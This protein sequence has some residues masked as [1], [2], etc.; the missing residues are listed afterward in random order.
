[1]AKKYSLNFD[2]QYTP[3]FRTEFLDMT[4]DEKHWETVAIP[5]TNKEV[6]YNYFDEK[7]YQFESCY[8]KRITLPEKKKNKRWILHFDGV[9]VWAKVYLNGEFIGEHK[10]GYTP[11]SFDITEKAC[12]GEENS[13]VVYVDS[14]ENPNIPPFG[15]VVD[16]L[17]YG[18]IYRE[19]WLECVEDTYVEHCHI[20]TGKVLEAKK[21]IALDMEIKNYQ[22]VKEATLKLGLQFQGKEIESWSRKLKLTGVLDQQVGVDFLLEKEVQLWDIHSPNLYTFCVELVT[23]DSCHQQ[24][25]V[26]GFREIHYT[27]D[28]FFLNGKNVKLRGL[29][30]HQSFP[31]IGYAMPES[32]QKK[33]ADILKY[34]LGVNVVRSSHYPPSDHFLNRCDEIG[35]L[36]FD[37]IPGWQHIGE[38][39]Q[40]WDITKQH[41]REMIYKDWNHPSV[42]IWGVRINESQD[43]DVL[44]SE[45]NAIAREMDWSRPTG[46][47]RCIGGS[48]LL[49]DVYTYNDFVHDGGRVVLDKPKKIAKKKV[50][51]LVTEYNG[52]MFPTKKFDPQSRRVEHSLRHLRVMDK[53]MSDSDISGAIGWCMSDYNT[54]QEFGSGDKICYHGV[55]DMYRLPKYAASAYSAEGLETPVMNVAS[56]MDNGD[57]DK[58]IR[59]EVVVYTNCDSVKMYVNETYIKE[60]YP[61]KDM[62]AGVNHPPVIIDDFIGNQIADNE[63]FS[64]RDA[65]T[66]KTLLT[67][68]DRDGDNLPIPDMIKMGWLFLKYKM[69]VQN[70]SDLYTKYFGGWGSAATQYRFEGYKDGQCVITKHKSQV[71][72]PSLSLE[73]DGE[74]LFEEN[75]YDTVRGVIRLVDEW[76]ETCEYGQSAV[77]VEVDGCIQLI[78]PKQLSLIGGSIAFWVKTIGQSGEGKITLR[79]ERFGSISQTVS[80]HK[81]E[82]EERM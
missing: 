59:G 16:Y 41:V 19:V 44:Y 30:R 42:F 15:F 25:I 34:D 9:M 70:A 27:V 82:V 47:V 6:P 17:T 55:L 62:Y 18:G 23:K 60:F 61:R 2:W 79:S 1:M 14:R 53:M 52:H 50:P 13:L 26:T 51:Y 46:G 35:L 80:V 29:N 73:M 12:Y 78:G 21:E 36:V 54:H 10:G 77:T 49:E 37:E 4:Y 48:N 64:T 63:V 3:E 5:H 38:E 24:N 33:D 66:I 8:K 81:K 76:G 22:E 40:W 71:F 32:G 75:T 28:G 72:S 11:F 43:E 31:Y 57:M 65:K 69:N 7:S 20:M 74:T 58:S 39:G 45:T 68:V 56:T 67:K